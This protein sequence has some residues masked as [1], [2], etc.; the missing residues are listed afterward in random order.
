MAGRDR[1]LVAGFGH[2][3]T[4]C[5][6]AATADVVNYDVKRRLGEWESAFVGAAGSFRQAIVARS[7]D[8]AITLRDRLNAG[9][10]TAVRELVAVRG[11]SQAKVEVL[12]AVLDAAFGADA[13]AQQVRAQ[14]RELAWVVIDADERA[15]SEVRRKLI[16]LATP[17]PEIPQWDVPAA[18][19]FRAVIFDLD[20]TLVD[21][22]SLLTPDARRAW[23]GNGDR[24]LVRTFELGGAVSPHDLP[25]LLADR[26]VKVAI[27]TRAPAEYTKRVCSLFGIHADVIQSGQGDK[28]S[29][30]QAVERE[31]GVA[32]TDVVVVGD[33]AS[34]VLAARDTGAVSVGVL[35]GGERWP[36]RL[37]PD[38]TCG[39]PSLLL[40]IGDWRRLGFLGELDLETDPF[41][42]TGSWIA[43]GMPERRALGRY[44][45]KASARHGDPLTE[46]IL[47]WK[48]RTDA[49]PAIARALQLLGKRVAD[50]A[51]VDLVTSIPPSS[52]RKDRFTAYRELAASAFGAEAA[53]VLRMSRDLLG[54]KTLG[55]EARIRESAGRFTAESGVGGMHVLVLDDVTTSGATF[56]AAEEALSAA[57]AARISCL[58]F[59]A[60]QD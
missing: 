30:I 31:F 41:V 53:S 51:A 39:D 47:A 58:S 52:G 19:P 33:D 48:G 22:S 44:F 35:W 21:S 15:V 32:L 57:G 8:E 1:R 9:S 14:L 11:L 45:V 36:D 56:L 26:A 20:Q 37:Q 24:A 42:H 16:E 34:D 29:K 27:V 55:H 5:G 54:Y 12:R 50:Q 17:E 49:H 25:G 59:A 38:I 2:Q 10:A 23:M 18:F 4:S 60:T 13:H 3:L 46:A 40:R 28:A 7:H 43:Y 6:W